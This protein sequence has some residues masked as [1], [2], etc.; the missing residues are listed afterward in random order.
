M[1]SLMDLALNDLPDRKPVP[2]GEQYRLLIT[3]AEYVD[4]AAGDG[5]NIRV[6]LEIADPPYPTENIF[7]YLALP[8]DSDDGIK[9]ERKKR[10]IKEFLQAFDMDPAMP[11]EPIDWAGKEGWAILGVEEFEGVLSNRVKRLIKR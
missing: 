11:P 6:I 8:K 4:N 2:A 10:M 7:H 5:K 3:K 1:S 9:V